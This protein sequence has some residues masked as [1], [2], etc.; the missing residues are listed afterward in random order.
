MN[1]SGTRE[2]LYATLS[3]GEGD[4]LITAEMRTQFNAQGVAANT[5]ITVVGSRRFG[6]RSPQRVKEA[7]EVG[8]IGDGPFVVVLRHNATEECLL[9]V[10][11]ETSSESSTIEALDVCEGEKRASMAITLPI[12][13][14]PLAVSPETRLLK[15]DLPRDLFQSLPMFQIQAYALSARARIQLDPP[16]DIYGKLELTSPKTAKLIVTFRPPASHPQFIRNFTF[17]FSPTNEKIVFV[18]VSDEGPASHDGENTIRYSQL[19]QAQRNKTIHF[20][21]RP[22]SNTSIRATTLLQHLRI[23]L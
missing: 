16:C 9:I 1:V 22:R 21:V 15:F 7:L 20:E 10:Y 11:G 14:Q 2:R 8:V 12:E 17:V 19:L 5:N 13:A 18:V 23:V 6:S 3:R 4:Y